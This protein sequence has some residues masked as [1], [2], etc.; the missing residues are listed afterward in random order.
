MFATGKAS[1]AS[2]AFRIWPQDVLPTNLNSVKIA[3][4][5]IRGRGFA[6]YKVTDAGIERANE[7]RDEL[8]AK[9]DALRSKK[10]NTVDPINL[11]NPINSVFSF[12]KAPW[13]PSN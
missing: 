13:L 1:C 8:N 12:E 7:V 3:Y 6:R 5:R 4:S 2:E 10:K 9:L 11:T